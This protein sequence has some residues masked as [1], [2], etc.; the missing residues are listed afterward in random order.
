LYT[1]WDFEG[2]RP[3]LEKAIALS[4]H[5]SITRHSYADYF[6]ITGQFE[7]SL[8]QVRMGRDADPISAFPQAAVFFHAMALRRFDVVIEEGRLALK[9][10]PAIAPM[11]HGAIGD[12]LWR[13]G[14]H[15]DALPELK[16]SLGQNADGWRAFEDAYRRGGPQ[17]AYRAYGDYLA[18]HAAESGGTIAVAAAYAEAGDADQ[19]MPWLEKALSA[20]RPQLLHVPAN[21]AFDAIRDDPRFGDLLRRIGVRPR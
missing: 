21:P 13:Q 5:D 3:L 12:A 11:A 8:E 18:A 15:E 6:M 19:A 20:R 1:D 14:K 16:L 7:T 2:A 10:F 9:L 4:P 17:R